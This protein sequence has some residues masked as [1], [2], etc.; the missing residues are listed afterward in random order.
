MAL[1]V[2]FAVESP[3]SCPVAQ[4]SERAGTPVD[5][6]ARASIAG[7]GPITEE[8]RL[9]AGA[10]LD[11]DGA[12]EDDLEP[13]ATD[14]NETV[15]RFDRDLA[16]DCV[17]ETIERIAGP[18]SNVRAEAGTLVVTATVADLETVREVVERLRE[19]FDGVSVR[20]LENLDAGADD[21]E[22]AVPDD[23]L[24]AR[25]REVLRT[26]YEMGYFEYPKGAN[27]GEVADALDISRSTLA[28]HLAAATGK[29]FE[30]LLGPGAAVTPAVTR[31]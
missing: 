18:A 12:V 20:R 30:S 28:E 15:Y 25:Q 5:G 10:S 27:A 1:A 13:V 26:A 22:A 7:D 8:F 16:N 19:P 6:V 4:A 24:T 17:C 2:E 31:P 14:E 21:E 9:P 23:R 3:G 11:G 29:L